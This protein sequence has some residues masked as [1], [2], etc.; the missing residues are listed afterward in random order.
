ML[1]Y[2]G[3]R[4]ITEHTDAETPADIHDQAMIPRFD[5]HGKKGGFISIGNLTYRG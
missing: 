3:G 4:Q 5:Y 2:P 1:T